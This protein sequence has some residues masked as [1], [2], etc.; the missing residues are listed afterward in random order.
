MVLH[1]KVCGR[2]GDRRHIIE[3][4]APKER[5]F[6]VFCRSA[7]PLVDCLVT[8]LTLPG[9][10]GM[11]LLSVERDFAVFVRS[12]ADKAR[13]RTPMTTWFQRSATAAVSLVLLLAGML[14]VHLQTRRPVRGPG[15]TRGPARTHNRQNRF[16]AD[17]QS[18]S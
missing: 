14:A 18:R 1:A 9:A 2:L 13:W 5:A 7:A 15:S 10:A 16:L 17:V 11:V 4:P 6:A 3:K 8:T 12:P